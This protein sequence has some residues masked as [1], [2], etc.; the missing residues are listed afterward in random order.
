MSDASAG[1]KAL[2]SGTT[3]LW[4]VVGEDG[5]VRRVKVSRSLSRHQDAMAVDAVKK[6]KFELATKRGIPVAVELGVEV[7]F[8]PYH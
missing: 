8:H 2:K 3:L 7:E 6:W 1:K 5:S 4:I